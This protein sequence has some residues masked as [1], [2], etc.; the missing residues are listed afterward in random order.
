MQAIVL[1]ETQQLLFNQKYD[2]IKLVRS[3]FMYKPCMMYGIG[4]LLFWIKQS[5][6]INRDYQMLIFLPFIE[7]HIVRSSS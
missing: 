1:P 7:E 2:H 6:L 3:N 4:S 5:Q